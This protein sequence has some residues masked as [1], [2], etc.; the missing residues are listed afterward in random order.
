MRGKE[1]MR[2]ER[3]QP[4]SKQRSHGKQLSRSDDTPSPGILVPG[5][6]GLGEDSAS[7]THPGGLGQPTP[8]SARRP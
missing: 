4:Q 7:E 5:R 8:G 2:L 6:E 1:K 3:D